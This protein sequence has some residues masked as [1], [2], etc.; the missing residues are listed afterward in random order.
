[1]QNRWSVRLRA[2][3]LD[4]PDDPVAGAIGRNG[5]CGTETAEA[6]SGHGRRHGCD[7]TVR[8]G[9]SFQYT[10]NPLIIQLIIEIGRGAENSPRVRLDDLHNLMIIR[11]VI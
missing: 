8:Y 6:G 9:I 3:G 1:M 11:L 5:W 7:V 10:A 2:V 4:G